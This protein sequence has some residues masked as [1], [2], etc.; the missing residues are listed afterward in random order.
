MILG[1]NYG[2]QRLREMALELSDMAKAIENDNESVFRFSRARPTDRDEI[3]TSELMK[4]AQQEYQLRRA[5]APA[6]P[7]SLLGEPAWDLLL[8]LFV[9][10]AQGKMIST[11]S[12]CIASGVPMTTAL[13]YIKLLEAQELI[14]AVQ[15]RSDERVRLLKL[16]PKGQQIMTDYLSRRYRLSASFNRDEGATGR[17]EAMHSL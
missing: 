8:D 15:N 6:L 5:R 9:H 3:I 2:A 14:Q 4:Q 11:S 1:E 17:A 10:E 7:T 13:R 16:S 12:A